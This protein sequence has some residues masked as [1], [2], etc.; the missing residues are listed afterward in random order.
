MAQNPAVD[1]VDGATG[2]SVQNGNII[3]PKLSL[4]D[5]VSLE[6]QDPEYLLI[7]AKGGL[8]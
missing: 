1:N 6:L 2:H 7:E 3:S 5:K 8:E 4:N